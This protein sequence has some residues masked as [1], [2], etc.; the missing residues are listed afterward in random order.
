MR[1]IEAAMLV[2]PAGRSDMIVSRPASA[3]AQPPVRSWTKT[4][5]VAGS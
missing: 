4:S 5:G 1:E 2:R 3:P